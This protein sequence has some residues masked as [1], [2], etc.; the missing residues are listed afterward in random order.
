M[1]IQD[2]ALNAS[3]TVCPNHIVEPDH[4][5]I[6][7]RKRGVGELEKYFVSGKSIYYNEEID[8]KKISNHKKQMWY[9]SQ[10]FQ[11]NMGNEYSKRQG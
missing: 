8:W 9:D 4:L 10:N 3:I 11:I 6:W 5:K 7:W 2:F 1:K